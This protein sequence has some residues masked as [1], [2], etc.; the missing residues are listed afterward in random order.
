MAGISRFWATNPYRAAVGIN[1]NAHELRFGSRY[2]SQED[3][4]EP[5]RANSTRE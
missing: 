5:T 2:R 4:T 3:G 1:L